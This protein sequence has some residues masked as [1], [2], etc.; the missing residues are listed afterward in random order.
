MLVVLAVLG[1]LIGLLWLLRRKGVAQMRLPS[2]KRSAARKLELLERM[3]L[4]A[5][6]SLH[7]VRAGDT[8]LLVGLSP[9]SCQMLITLPPSAQPAPNADNVLSWE[10]S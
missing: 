9:S 8:V 2:R 1:G 6:H 4:S 10:G 5:T 3:P 7:L